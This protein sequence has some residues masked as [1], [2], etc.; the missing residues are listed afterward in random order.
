MPQGIQSSEYFQAE[1]RRIERIRKRI[2]ATKGLAFQGA[3]RRIA[4][5]KDAARKK[6]IELDTKK[7]AAIQKAND[8][9][10]HITAALA[11][12]RKKLAVLRKKK[13]KRN[14]QD[15]FEYLKVRIPQLEQLLKKHEEGKTQ[16]RKEKETEL[17]EIQK[18]KDTVLRLM[19]RIL[20]IES[21]I[22]DEQAR[23]T[24]RRWI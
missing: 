4:I 11:H 12:G 8:S 9:P 20:A 5:L 14:E 2:E 23:R 7:N 10:T 6:L 15:D 17:A 19:T 3:A 16:R 13:R 22:K 24:P 1:L 18:Q 21:A